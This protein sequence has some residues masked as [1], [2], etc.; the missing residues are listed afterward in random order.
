MHTAGARE[1]LEHEHTPNAIRIR[2]AKESSQNYLRDFV[3]GGVDGTVTTFAVVAG[4]IGASLDP[5]IVLILGVANLIADG[6][7]MAASNFLGTRAERDDHERIAQI[8]AKH[9]DLNPS[10]EREEIRQIYAAKGF[11]G[12]DLESIVDIITADRERWIRTMLAEEYGLPKQVRSEWTA[13]VS[14]FAAFVLCGS[15]PMLPFVFG[16]DTAFPI[17]AALTGLAF[18][19][20]G[21]IKARWSTSPWWW[22]GSVTFPFC[23]SKPYAPFGKDVLLFNHYY[24]NKS[25]N[26][27]YSEL[28]IAR[29][30]SLFGKNLRE[31]TQ[32]VAKNFPI[33]KSSIFQQPA[34]IGLPLNIL[35][36]HRLNIDMRRR[37]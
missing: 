34:N 7:S 3:Y 31:I 9:I 12:S 5:R 11:E 35:L 8:E 30:P 36:A 1:Y 22:S 17:S 24:G 14:T 32:L 21:S 29:E 15:V 23:V 2:L 18:F 16:A 28:E 20:I 26:L 10:G 13:A 33:E 27:Y 37:S 25:S 4:T 19:S 6:F